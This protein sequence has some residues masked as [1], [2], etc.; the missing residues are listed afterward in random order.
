MG[1]IIN[2]DSQSFVEKIIYLLLSNKNYVHF[3]W[4]ELIFTIVS[5][6]NAGNREDIYKYKYTCIYINNYRP[7]ILINF[8]TNI[9]R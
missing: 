3:I 9:H 2:V 7:T 4:G 5:I 1:M 6:Y 8:H